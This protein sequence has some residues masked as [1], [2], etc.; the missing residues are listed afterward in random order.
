MSANRYLFALQNIVAY[1]SSNNM[2]HLIVQFICFSQRQ[3]H[4]Q[5]LE[6]GRAVLC[7]ASTTQRLFVS[8]RLHTMR[9]EAVH[10][11]LPTHGQLGAQSKD[12]F[13]DTQ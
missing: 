1:I 6:L 12:A 2:M 4:Q 13:L 11:L 5:Q 10:E 8:Q 9:T 3:V 7:D